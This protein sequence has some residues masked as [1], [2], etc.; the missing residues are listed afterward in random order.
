[1]PHSWDVGGYFHTVGE[2]NSGDLTNGRVR[3][4]RGLRS[5]LG[6]YTSLEW[7]R[8]EGWTILECVKTASKRKHARLGRFVFSASLRELVNGWHL[9]KKTRGGSVTI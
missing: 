5:Y 3:L 2:A 1:M 8:V 6:T 4:P 9:E 7:R